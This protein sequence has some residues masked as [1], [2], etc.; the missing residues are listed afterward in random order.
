MV[1]KFITLVVAPNALPK[2]LLALYDNGIENV[3]I[4]RDGNGNLNVFIEVFMLKDKE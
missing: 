3:E 2:L 4:D 1:K